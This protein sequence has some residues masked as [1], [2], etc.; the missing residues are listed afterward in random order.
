[1]P[2]SSWE[3]SAMRSQTAEQI[4]SIFNAQSVALVGAT[5]R[6]GTFGRLFLEGLRDL[7]CPHIFPVNPKRE[8]LLGFK[9]YPS[10]SAIPDSVD[11][12]V[13]LTPTE[14]IPGLVK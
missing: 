8:E 11:I 14:S 10:L 4:S 6:E 13:L 7:G 1:M 12:A 3:R 9:A 2:A 5:D